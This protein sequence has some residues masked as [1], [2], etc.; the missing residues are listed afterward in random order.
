MPRKRLLLFLFVLMALGIMTYQST[1]QP[2]VPLRFLSGVLNLFYDAKD[3]V[4]E[5]VS[6]PFRRMALREEENRRLRAEVSQLRQEQQRWQEVF[7]EN[8]KLRALLSIKEREL[9]YVASARIIARGTEQWSNTF[10]LDKGM[11]DGILKDMVA[12]TDKG[13]V[14][15]ISEVS[16]SYAYLLLLT[17]INF[18]SAARL[19]SGRTEGILSG[20]GLRSCQLKYIPYD[21]ELKRG[22]VVI[23]SGLDTLF[24]PGIPLGFISKVSKREGGLFQHIEVI[25]FVDNSRV[26]VVTIIR[27][28]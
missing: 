23:T 24:P 3:A 8:E 14:G 10:V 27:R 7:H 2:L 28:A 19:Q 16:P 26:E 1:R 21:E 6:S 5:F 12:V 13:L 22:D 15:K 18:S 20:T 9:H 4:V 11:K 17:D 25:P